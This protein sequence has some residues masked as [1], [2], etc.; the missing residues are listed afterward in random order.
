[1]ADGVKGTL[2]QL[3]AD[4]Q[5]AVVKPVTDE[6]G[7]ALETGV[8]TVIHGPQ[9]TPVDPNLQAQKKVEE[10]KRKQWAHRVIDWH[11][12]LANEQHKVRMQKQQK[13]TEET[14]VKQQ[15]EQVKNVQLEQRKKQI[16]AELAAKN[17]TERRKGVGG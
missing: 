15:E 8:K 2:S 10:E 16:P 3:G 7:K 11:K 6:V 9:S 4:I 17:T 5:E 14:Q 1:M 12:N 13:Q